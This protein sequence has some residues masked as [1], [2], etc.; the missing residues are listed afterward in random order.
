MKTVRIFGY[1]LSRIRLAE[2]IQK[3]VTPILEIQYSIPLCMQGPPQS[4]PEQSEELLSGGVTECAADR[5]PG[6]VSQNELF[7]IKFTDFCGIDPITLMTL[8]ETEAG[9]SVKG[10]QKISEK[11]YYFNVSGAMLTGWQKINNIWPE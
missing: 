1:L 3:K 7:M 9:A 5:N 11:W 4:Y 6:A 8:N 2:I 10:W